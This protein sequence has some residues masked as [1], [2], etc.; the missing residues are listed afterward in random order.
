MYKEGERKDERTF[1]Y[2]NCQMR[3]SRAAHEYKVDSEG[4]QRQGTN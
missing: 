1:N 2:F 3:A 4:F